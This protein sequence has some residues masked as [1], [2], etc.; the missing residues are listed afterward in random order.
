MHSERKWKLQQIQ[1][2]A[3]R[4]ATMMRRD[5]LKRALKA[6]VFTPFCLSTFSAICSLV[7]VERMWPSALRAKRTDMAAEPG[8]KIA[9]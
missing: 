5:S 4:L 2:K 8:K 1:N 3:L 7:L 9:H 6:C